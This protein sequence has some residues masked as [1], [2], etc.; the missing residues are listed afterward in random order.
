MFSN[1]I[2]YK[3]SFLICTVFILWSCSP[4]LTG[5]S[6]LAGTSEQGTILLQ[7]QGYGNTKANALENAEINAFNNVVFKGIPG[8]AYRVPLIDNE[9]N[10]KQTHNDYFQQL[11]SEKKYKAFLLSSSAQSDFKLKTSGQSNLTS[12]VKIDVQ[13]LRKDMEQKGVIRKFGF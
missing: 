10:A 7:S 8:S 6:T 2:R 13:A 11:F 1:C 4:K 5:E 3:L 9:Q 12:L